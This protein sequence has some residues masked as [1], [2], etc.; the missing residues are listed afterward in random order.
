MADQLVVRMHDVGLGDCIHCRIPKAR[1]DGADFNILIDCGSLGSLDTLGRAI[2]ALKKELPVVAGKT[3][4]DLLI[5]THE[6]KDHMYGFQLDAW[7]EFSFGAIWMSVAMDPSHKSAT[8]TRKLQAFANRA[9]TTAMA[10]NQWMSPD[11]EALALAAASNEAAMTALRTTL[12][13]ASKIKP[14]YVHADTPAAQLKLPIKGAKIS[15]LGPEQ[16][17]DHFYIGGDASLHGLMGI[18]DSGEPEPMVSPV[19]PKNTPSNIDPGDFRQL[20]GRMLSSALALA[21]VSNSVVNNTSVVVLIE[22]E[23]QRLLFVGDAEW[24][25]GFKDGER[26]SSWNTMFHKRAKQLAAPLSFLKVGHHGSINATPWP[27]PSVKGT[28]PSQILDAILPK[29]S[30]K[31][32]VALVSTKRSTCQSIP[33]AALLAVLGSRVSNGRTYES[34]FK[35]ASVPTTGL[36]YFK[37]REAASFASAQPPR[38]DLEAALSGSSF[39]EVKLTAAS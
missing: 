5:V 31:A 18:I 35:K 33:E 38:T 14:L 32:A 8:K 12:P 3:H 28:E 4:V 10:S 37:E 15:V 24:Q 17:I 25:V 23:G 21:D 13:K 39:V 9:L 16:D 36:K 20:Q 29:A 30:K 2:D 34:L 11:V 22:W 1:A 7:N 26:N 27:A 19:T 6:H